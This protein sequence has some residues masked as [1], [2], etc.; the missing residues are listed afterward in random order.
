MFVLGLD[1]M[2]PSILYEKPREVGFEYLADIVEDS[3][4]YVMR[5]CHPP[6]TV[7]AWMVMFTGKT[8]GEL[9]IYGFRHRRPGEFKPYIVNSSFIREPTLWDIAGEKGL[10]SIVFGVP[11]TYPPKPIHGIL[12]TDFT[13]PGPEKPYTWPPWVKKEIESIAGPL[14]FDIVYRS[15]D[16]ERVRRELFEMLEQHLRVVRYLAT[17][18]KWD[19][20]VYVEIGVD[21][22][23]HAFWKYFDTQHP[24]HEE[25]PVYSRVIPEVYQRIDKWFRKLHKKLPRDT[26]IVIASDHGIKAMKG[27][28][29]INQWLAEQGYL[30]LRKEPEKP[31]TDLTEDM[32]DWEGTIAWA[33]GGYYSRVYIN[34][35]GREPRGTVDP[36]YYEETVKQL[37]RDLE[38]IRGPQGEQWENLVYQPSELY[39][40]VR[41]DA[42]DLMVYLDNLSWRPAGTIGWPSNYLP[43]NDR[44]PDDAV[45]DW[46]GV[47]A[48]YDPEG[49]IGRG[50]A[51]IIDANNVASLLLELVVR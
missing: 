10:R 41:G 30:K 37:K 19:L 6:I 16:K 34:L 32:I 24:R 1:S 12:V 28:F 3:K 14:I 50:D 11:P 49:T 22:A 45:H 4:R 46:N 39:P 35:K 51:G 2:P 48:I 8:P 20:F 26:V 5:S 18:K 27:A 9:G 38:K 33:W 25:H 15:E 17:S 23:H 21:R 36:K 29:A 40:V 44:G 47:L 13:T 31:G 7:P 42:P 43:E